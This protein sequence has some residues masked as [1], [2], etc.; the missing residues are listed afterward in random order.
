[1]AGHRAYLVSRLGEV[2]IPL[3]FTGDPRANPNHLPT[4]QDHL[5]AQLGGR[6]GAQEPAAP[7]SN[8]LSRRDARARQDDPT[9][10]LRPILTAQS[11]SPLP[12]RPR[13]KPPM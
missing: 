9:G 10:G 3:T 11:S 6:D 5:R 8:S 13:P 12:L 2:A 7:A 1:M 4:D